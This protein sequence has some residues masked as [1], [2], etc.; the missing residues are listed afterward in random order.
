[1]KIDVQKAQMFDRY[2][3][4]LLGWIR[5]FYKK[6]KGIPLLY[7]LYFFI[8]QKILR[9]NGNVPWP[10]HFTSRI[11]FAKNITVGNRTAPGMNAHCY[12]QARN[13]IIFGNNV[14][15]GPGVGII[16]A[17][18]SMN[19]YDV[20][21]LTLPITIGD[22]VWVGMNAIIL[23]GITVGDNVAIG[24]GSVVTSNIP[25]DSIAVGNPCRVI[26]KK[27]PYTGNSYQD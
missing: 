6:A 4:Y 11:L 9:I 25:S 19:D 5:L 16:S 17:S 24:A 18:H 12:V 8:P 3:C 13:G 23:P 27:P 21:A 14:R 2:L 10:V 20:H 7:L 26:K 15:I 22:N 1:M